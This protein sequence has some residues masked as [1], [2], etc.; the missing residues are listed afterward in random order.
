M[1]LNYAPSF[2]PDNFLHPEN[3]FNSNT[4]SDFIFP[5]WNSV[6]KSFISLFISSIITF[7][8]TFS[9]L[10]FLEVW[11]PQ[12]STVLHEF[13]YRRAWC[14]LFCFKCS[15]LIISW[16]LMSFFYKEKYWACSQVLSWDWKIYLKCAFSLD[17]A[18][19]FSKF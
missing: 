17:L 15:S 9:L 10:L 3:T 4:S 8:W 13:L 7:S 5:N 6:F 12:R 18:S 14:V 11:C 19:Y 2:C 1:Q 16:T